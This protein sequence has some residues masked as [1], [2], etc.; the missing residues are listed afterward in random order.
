[1]DSRLKRSLEI[2]P[3]LARQHATA[4]AAIV[5]SGQPSIDESL[6]QAWARALQH[7]GLNVNDDESAVAQLFPIIKGNT[8]RFTEIFRTAPVWLLQ[9]TGMAMDAR[10]L[11]FNLPDV[12]KKL[13]WGSAGY[14]DA[15]RWPLLPVGTMKAGAPIPDFDPRQL[16]IILFCMMTEPILDFADILS[17][18]D[19]E[20]PEDRDERVIEDILLFAD[21]DK[22]PEKE[23]SRY[24]KRRMRKLAEWILAYK[25]DEFLASDRAIS[26]VVSRRSQ[27]I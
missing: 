9:F 22:K 26:K 18:E 23:W 1:R 8:A 10:L 3:I 15:R 2:W 19:E 14:E 5:L 4:V 25:D 7:Y 6:S 16:W 12:S 13:R 20:T 27:P 24:E 21:L 17:R 11:K